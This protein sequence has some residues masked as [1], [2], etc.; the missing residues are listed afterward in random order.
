[1]YPFKCLIGALD[2]EILDVTAI[3]R[4]VALNQDEIV[5]GS[6]VL[7]ESRLTGWQG[8]APF[9]YSGEYVCR[10]SRRKTILAVLLFSSHTSSPPSLRLKAKKCQQLGE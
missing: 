7:P 2:D 3:A 5:L 4:E 1:M 10:I 9:Y 8:T 6:K